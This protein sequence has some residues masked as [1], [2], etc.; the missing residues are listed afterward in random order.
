MSDLDMKRQMYGELKKFAKAE[1]AR[2]IGGRH[3]RK[4][5]MPWDVEEVTIEAA[6]P[7]SAEAPTAGLKLDQDEL[8]AL[9]AS[10]G[11]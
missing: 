9:T 2:E 8:D 10:L 5:K 4:V 11:G 6:E 7:E 1:M 3:G